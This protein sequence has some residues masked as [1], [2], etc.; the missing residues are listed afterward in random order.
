ME[1]REELLGGLGE[2]LNII[3]NVANLNNKLNNVRSQYKINWQR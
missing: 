2:A 1:T 3:Q